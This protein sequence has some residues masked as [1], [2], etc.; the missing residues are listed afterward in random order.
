[1]VRLFA[2]FMKGLFKKLILGKQFGL[3]IMQNDSIVVCMLNLLMNKKGT[4]I[5]FSVEDHHFHG[6]ILS[7]SCI[8]VHTMVSLSSIICYRKFV[9]LEY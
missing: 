3:Y 8:C 9:I 7:S 6:M 5:C 2:F 4:K 1:M